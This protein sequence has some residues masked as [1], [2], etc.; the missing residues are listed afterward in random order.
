MASLT[1][2][3]SSFSLIWCTVP[4]MR[5]QWWITV[6]AAMAVWPSL[7]HAENLVKD[8][9]KAV[10]RGTLDQAGT[11]PFHLKAVLAPSFD[12]DKDS[13]RTGEV[14]IWWASPTQWKREVRSS[15]FH[16]IEIV[17]AAHD[18]QKNEGDYF[19]EWLREIAVELIKPVPPLDQVLEQVKTAEVRRMGPMTNLSWTTTTGTAEVKNILRSWVAL[20][21][22][23]GLLLICRWF[24][25]G[26][27]V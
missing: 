18:W 5:G 26:R 27:R 15:E 16:Q 1:A 21:D 12:R 6:F 13:G 25:M 10:E 8:V 3:W 14:E 20:Q 22:S 23:T 4:R 17:D 2:F 9:K 19:P 24:R 11:K 7:G